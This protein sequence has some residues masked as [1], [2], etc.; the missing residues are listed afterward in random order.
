MNNNINELFENVYDNLKNHLINYQK[1]KW[2][3]LT[4][5][6]SENKKRILSSVS[7]LNN[8]FLSDS[9]YLELIGLYKKFPKKFND[10]QKRTFENIK[11]INFLIK[12]TPQQ[13]NYYD[14]LIIVIM[15]LI[16]TRINFNNKETTTSHLADLS[17]HA[18]SLHDIKKIQTHFFKPIENFKDKIKNILYLRNQYAK[19]K[20][21]NNYYEFFLKVNNLKD[22]M[23][24]KHIKELD[25]LTCEEYKK[26]KTNLEEEVSKK[27]KLQAQNVPSYIYGDPF[28]RTYPVHLDENVN[29]MFKGKDIAY[30]AK[31]FFEIMGYD[32][33]DIFEI[34]DLYIRPGKYQYPFIVDIDENDIR[35]SINTKSNFRGT[36]WAL[37]TLSK[38]IYIREISKNKN[39]FL[40]GEYKREK[41][42]AFSIL[43]TNF[44][45][46]SGII[47][48]ILA[49]YEDEDEENIPIDISNY[50]VKNNLIL[51]RFLLTLSNFEINID[52]SYEKNSLTDL[53]TKSVKKFQFINPENIYYQ[54]GWVLLDSIII[55]PFSSVFEMEGFLLS[56]KLEEKLDFKNIKQKDF[57]KNLFE[58][59][60]KM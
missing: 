21:Y 3:L 15:E 38:V 18:V 11:R 45:F 50:T 46:T 32:L 51:I 31:K 39:F 59:I 16:N 12:S 49:Q 57:V 35:F 7:D 52:E 1:E 8:Y 54:D 40:K 4:N 24:R 23:I 37:R 55:D 42:E 29:T 58:I 2:N 19:S 41:I 28:F 36:Y 5:A 60:E 13:E 22:E 43:V 20:N 25:S 30:T 17:E 14:E 10:E 33:N 34:S 9:N 6:T 56:K 48:K 47:S 26:L 27:L 53:W 44:A